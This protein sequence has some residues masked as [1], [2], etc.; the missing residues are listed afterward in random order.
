M[1]QGVC[2]S[3]LLELSLS[4]ISFFLIGPESSVGPPGG[5]EQGRWGQALREG[6]RCWFVALAWGGGLPYGSRASASLGLKIHGYESPLL[7]I[8]L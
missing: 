5:H 7:A 2:G 8:F 6:C 1:S 4:L 3:L